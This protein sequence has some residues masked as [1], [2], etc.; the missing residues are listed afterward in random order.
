MRLDSILAKILL[1]FLISFICVSSALSREGIASRRNVSPLDFGL[2]EAK[3]GVER[4]DVLLRTHQAAVQRGVN[5]SYKGI[6]KIEIEI[7]KNATRIPLTD[8]NDFGGCEF[9]ITNQQNTVYLFESLAS[10]KPIVISKSDIDKGDFRSYWDLSNGR[11]ILII[12]D[13]NPWVENRKGYAY[14]HIRRDILLVENGMALNAVVMPYDNVQSTPICA[15]IDAKSLTFKNL[16]IRRTEDCTDITN[17]MF[18]TGR[19]N[20]E[21]SNVNLHTP[22]NEW[23]NDRAIRIENCT[24]V[25]FKDVLIDGTY[26]QKEH[27][28]YGISL[29]NIWNFSANHLVGRGNWG[30]FGTNNVNTA[31]IENSDINR[32][33]I[34]CY[35]RDISFSHVDFSE[36]Y[37]QLASV[38][39]DVVFDHCTF[40]RFNPIVNGKSYNAYVG[41]DVYFNDCTFNVTKGNNCLLRLGEIN[42]EINARKELAEKCWPNVYIKNLT[43]NIDETVTEFVIFYT[44]IDGKESY[45]PIHYLSTVDVQ[46]LTINSPK[47]QMQISITPKP[48]RVMNLVN[49]SMSDVSVNGQPIENNR[50]VRIK[51][52]ISLKNGAIK[53]TN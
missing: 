13:S 33:D 14:G 15:Y 28:G 50:K 46:G 51:T 47:D 48:I 16:T 8:N 27:S 45:M 52:N 31:H 53:F 36:R 39:G 49:C 18:I 22:N 25:H 4:Y 2:L 43:V 41:Y 44:K 19:D 24:N 12:K 32:F 10:T 26:S 35:G 21:I 34:H 29:N 20:V 30:I 9:V 11:H 1:A 5:V 38:Y 17:V 37:N 7:P 23:R 6:N 3:N 40:T 42:D